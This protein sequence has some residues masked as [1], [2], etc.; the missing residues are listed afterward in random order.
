VIATLLFNPTQYTCYT[1]AAFVD[2]LSETG[3]VNI[4]MF[5]GT[6]D[7]VAIMVMLIAGK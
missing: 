6:T 1:F 7:L 2:L 4:L 5:R 3:N